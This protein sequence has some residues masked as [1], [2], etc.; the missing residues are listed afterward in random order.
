MNT[1]CPFTNLTGGYLIPLSSQLYIKHYI[2]Q[3]SL[4]NSVL[5]LDYIVIKA[6]YNDQ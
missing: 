1:N 6:L 4:N 5:L 3:W 2:N